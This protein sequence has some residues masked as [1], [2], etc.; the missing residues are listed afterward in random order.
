[1]A[2]IK[3][4]VV[5]EFVADT[6]KAEK[7][8]SKLTTAQ[9]KQQ[10]QTKSSSNTINKELGGAIEGLQANVV[11]ATGSLGSLV[12]QVVRV[13]QSMKVL[14]IA[15]ISS[16]IG[17]IVVALGT[18]FA[19]FTK[20][21]A[22][23]DKLAEVFAGIG[24]IIDELIG[25]AG[26]LAEAVG[27]FFAGDFKA[28][29]DLAAQATNNLNDS[30]RLAAIEAQA[31]V[32]ER[33]KFRDI[34]RDI[35]LTVAKNSAE[36][37]DLIFITRDSTKTFIEQR[38]ALSKAAEL[39]VANEEARLKIARDRVAFAEFELQNSAEG[40]ENQSLLNELNEAQI[41]LLNTQASSRAKQREILNRQNEFE[42]KVL[43]T[44]KLQTTELEK[45]AR[46]RAEESAAEFARD[47]EALEKEL[48]AQQ[49]LEE[50]NKIAFDELAEIEFKREELKENEF[51]GIRIHEVNKLI[52][53]SSFNHLHKLVALQP[54]T[55]KDK[56][57]FNIHRLLRAVDNN[58][59]LS[60]LGTHQQA[61]DNEVMMSE[62]QLINYYQQ[63]PQIVSNTRRLL[64]DCTFHLEFHTDKNKQAFTESK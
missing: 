41:T 7:N 47:E 52:G 48:A 17:A 30:L 43:A 3:N 26:K 60:K 28:A 8:V 27:K 20:T 61:P 62:D 10:K 23:G 1:M 2:D 21:Q 37:Q 55:F 25:R 35:N 45:Q 11:A 19:A 12:V 16:G 57:G 59:V 31:L 46:L 32:R 9:K 39:E 42:N 64:K 33:Q 38:A 22:G 5:T 13:V 53:S 63:Y 18:L 15:L 40:L 50:S 36:I 6:K 54:V 34:E 58:I 14:K 51:I 24:A 56:S 49:A 44:Q 4:T 29:A